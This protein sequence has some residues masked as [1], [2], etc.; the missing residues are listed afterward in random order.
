[1]HENS[2]WPLNGPSFFDSLKSPDVGFSTH[3]LS[4]ESRLRAQIL[5]HGWQADDQN[6]GKSQANGNQQLTRHF[7]EH[8][9]AFRAV[10]NT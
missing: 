9:V 7:Q 8:W 4:K 6:L 5:R 10:G 2:Y 3:R 1:M